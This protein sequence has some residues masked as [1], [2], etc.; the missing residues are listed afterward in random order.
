MGDFLNR[1]LWVQRFS[2]RET[3]HEE[4]ADHSLTSSKRELLS[5]QLEKWEGR[6]KTLNQKEDSTDRAE[7]KVILYD[8]ERNAMS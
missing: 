1:N 5:F 4:R 8:F 3:S 7:L 6:N 2:S